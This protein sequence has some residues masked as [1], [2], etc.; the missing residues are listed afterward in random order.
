MSS[1]AAFSASRT[2]SSTLSRSTPG[3]AATGA[4]LILALDQEER[5]D[6]VVGQSARSP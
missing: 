6:E 1:L 4:R 5:P 3:I 2:A